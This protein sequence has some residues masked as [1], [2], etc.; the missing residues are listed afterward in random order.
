MP[1]SVQSWVMPTAI[2][3]GARVDYQGREHVVTFVP[4]CLTGIH[5]GSDLPDGIVDYIEIIDPTTV[6]ARGKT[7]GR[8]V[9]VV[10]K[11]ITAR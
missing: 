6:D 7:K 3:E 1:R 2:I 11:E 4:N 5:Y 10:P 9:L 8:T